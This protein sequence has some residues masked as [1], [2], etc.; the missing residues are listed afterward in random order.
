MLQI[1]GKCL[2]HGP[3]WPQQW[4][5]QALFNVLFRDENTAGEL[6]FMQGRWITLKIA[7]LDLNLSLSLNARQQLQIRY[8]GTGDASIALS[9]R[10]AREIL[11][12]KT[13]PDTLFFQRELVISGNTD[14]A[15]HIKNTLDNKIWPPARHVLGQLPAALMKP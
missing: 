8:R 1:I 5:A 2:R 10:A 9:L 15:H 6:D 14:L 13:D 4:L 3:L 11:L 7:E 12:G